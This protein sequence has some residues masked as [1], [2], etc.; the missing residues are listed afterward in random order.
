MSYAGSV[1]LEFKPELDPPGKN[2]E[3]RDGLSAVVQV[4][5]TLWVANDETL[6]LERLS[7]QKGAADHDYKYSDHKQFALED[8]LSLPD[9]TKKTL[10]VD[11]EGLDYK[12]GYLWLIGSHSLKRGN[13]KPENSR[14]DNRKCLADVDPKSNRFLL[15]RIPLVEQ[16]K[17]FTLTKKVEQ[18]G[19]KYTAARL[20]G[21]KKGDDLTKVLADDEHLG[22]F[23]AIPSK[24]NGFD[25]EG[26]AVMGDRLFVG[27][28]GPVLGGWAVILEL[29]L[30]EKDDFTLKLKKIGPDNQPYRKHFLQLNGLGI[31]DLCVLDD[32]L[33][34]LA[35]P[36]M[37]L[38]GPVFLFRWAGGAKPEKQSLVF[39]EELK[40]SRV[41]LPSGQKE[42]FDHPEGITL[43]SLDGDGIDSILVVY[44]SAA[45]TRHEASSAVKADIFALPQY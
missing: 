15:A 17:T 40:R 41:K 22:S 30:E 32:D 39:K 31:R 4:G 29:E 45:E 28:R 12:D 25:I 18:G 23:L 10:E 9:P 16:G 19:K 37:M 27:L 24:D 6:T 20:R 5:N 44:D 35:G 36:T 21:D 33:L 38:D 34:I 26:L 11:L 7:R 2:S 8:Y 13:P 14:G 3:I 1:S 43:F 42:G